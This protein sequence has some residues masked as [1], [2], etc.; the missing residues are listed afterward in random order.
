MTVILMNAA[1]GYD[2]NLR[3]RYKDIYDLRR[4][5]KEVTALDRAIAKIS[6]LKPDRMM[7][8][9]GCL[10]GRAFDTLEAILDELNMGGPFFADL[11]LYSMRENIDHCLRGDS[12][13][14][15]SKSPPTIMVTTEEMMM[16]LIYSPN[17]SKDIEPCSLYLIT[18]A[19][20]N[21]TY[22]TKLL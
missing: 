14:G 20:G 7:S 2:L 21:G 10:H 18:A 12:Y 8:C 13:I 9:Q 6:E 3:D 16:N 5:Q 4:N 19:E 15:G 1:S 22:R 17:V 11:S